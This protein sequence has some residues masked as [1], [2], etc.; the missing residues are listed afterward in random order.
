MINLQEAI[1][2]FFGL[3][4]ASYLVLPRSVLQSMPDEWQQK[5]VSLLNQ[6]PETIDEDWEPEGG[7]RVRALDDKKKFISDPYSNYERGR[8]RLALKK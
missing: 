5:F 1:H 8:R 3:T 6:I 2:E 4:Y 7:Y